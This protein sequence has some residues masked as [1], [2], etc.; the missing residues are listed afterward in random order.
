LDFE[1]KNLIFPYFCFTESYFD[2]SI[3]YFLL[4]NQSKSIFLMIIFDF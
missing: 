1:L 2:S 3:F 4:I